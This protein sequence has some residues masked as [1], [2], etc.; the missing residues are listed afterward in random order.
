VSVPPITGPAAAANAENPA[1]IPSARPRWD[2][3]NTLL[4]IAI[5]VGIISAAPTPCVAR[6][7]ISH[8][9][10]W[11]APASA[12]EA[13]NIAAP[14]RNTFRSPIRSPSRPPN[15]IKAASGSTFAVRIHCE[16]SGLLC[17][18]STMCGIA[19]G[20]D[21]WSTRIMLADSVIAISVTTRARGVTDAVSPLLFFAGGM[22]EARPYWTRFGSD[23]QSNP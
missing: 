8:P 4:T 21:V 12:E 7:V 2:S 19:S 10:S 16:R 11:A 17:S 22:L 5:E 1:M 18:P 9:M 20:I 6:T 15:T 3:G 23:R 13:M 14:V